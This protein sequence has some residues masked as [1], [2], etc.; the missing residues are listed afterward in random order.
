MWLRRTAACA[1]TVPLALLLFR[2]SPVRL[3]APEPALLSGA[4]RPPVVSRATWHADE[5]MAKDVATSTGTVQAVFIHHTGHTNGYSCA[6]A[7]AMLRAMEEAHIRDQGWDDIGYNFVV[8]RCGTIYEGRAGSIGRSALGA[9]TTG[10]NAHSVGIAALGT[11][12]PGVP[13]SD[14]LIKG[15]AKVGAWKLDRA[16]DPRG[17]VRMVSSNDE[18]RYRRGEVVYLH[19]VAGHRDTYQ[20]RCPGDALYAQLPA[21][22]AEMAQLRAATQ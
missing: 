6:D 22:R 21:I 17:R 10:F 2:D 1:I 9:H 3:S 13:G 16:V 18:S 5:S 15:I 14:A 11:F 7:P 19:T 4:L 20:T 8:D 12:D